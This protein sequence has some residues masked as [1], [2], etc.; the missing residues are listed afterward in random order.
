MMRTMVDTLSVGTSG[1]LERCAE[2]LAGLTGWRR[3]AA[4]LAAGAVSGL[5]LPPLHLVFFLWPALAALMWLLDGCGRARTAAFV[6]WSFGFGFFLAGLYWVGFSFFVDAERFAFYMPIAVGGLAAGMALFTALAL[7]V[8]AVS[9]VKG[10]PRVL[11]LTA[12]WLFSDWLRAWVLTGFPWN[13]L[14]TVWSFSDALIQPAAWGGVWLLTALALLPAAASSLLIGG[15]HCRTP[16]SRV[17]VALAHLLLLAAWMGGELR[18][19]QAPAVDDWVVEGE[20]LRIVQPAI[21]QRLKWKA[22]LRA[23]HVLTQMRMSASDGYD[24]ITQVIWA[25]TAVPFLLED[26]P[27]LRRTLARVVPPGGFLFTG[28]PS[29]R[30]VD[31]EKVFRN[32]F[33]ALDG[34]GEIVQR[35]D[36]VHLVPF[37]EYNPL[38]DLLPAGALAVSAGNFEAGEGRQTWSLEGLPGASPLICYEVIFPGAV[39]RAEGPRPGWLLNVTNDAWF[40]RSSGPYQHFANARLRA[41]EEGL[42]LV[43]AANTGISG[44][45]DAYG[46]VVAQLGLGQ[47]G[48]VDAP[49]PKASAD[50]TLYAR[51]GNVTLLGLIVL[52]AGAA[53]VGRVAV[54]Q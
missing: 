44:V 34:L 49:L 25:E 2:Y 51:S 46:R 35:F 45:I 29:A 32:S 30:D 28:A 11:V 3:Q 38:G 33:F 26:D 42:P 47:T 18:L 13:F 22:E 53:F 15:S 14:G 41:V 23:D 31:G 37:G 43:R 8:T 5:A 9:G 1:T 20:R 27:A 6:G 16:G 17:F 21:P 48:V 19:R 36:K 52:L 24:G 50:I 7:F 54:R 40:G 4:A 10:W 12:A 39:V